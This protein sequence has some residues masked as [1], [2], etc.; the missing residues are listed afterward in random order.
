RSMARAAA[1][2]NGIAV[3]EA[4]ASSQLKTIASIL[5]ANR[6]RALQAL[7]LPGGL[8]TAGYIL[9]GLAAEKYPANEI[10]DVWARYLKNLQQTDGRWRIQAQRPPLESSDIQATATALRAL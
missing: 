7:G 9:L 4:V 3:N 2:S 1:R 10:T 6:E 5:E 8:D